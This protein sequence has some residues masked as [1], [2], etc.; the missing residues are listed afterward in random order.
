VITMCIDRPTV[1]MGDLVRDILPDLTCAVRCDAPVLITGD[2]EPGKKEIAAM[3]HRG[4]R[5]AAGRFLTVDCGSATD[6]LLEWKLFGRARGG[7]PGLDRDTRGLLEQAD[8]GTIFLAHVGALGPTLQARLARFL[9]NGQIRRV[10]ADQAHTLVDVRVIASA[11]RDL[12]AEVEAG[13]FSAPLYYQ[14]NVVHLLI[15][16]PP[17]FTPV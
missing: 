16:A 4:G 8:G 14:L 10:G 5:R 13:R 15:P 7:V 17:G 1:G 11:D 2:S 6:G 3:I 12:F 9:E